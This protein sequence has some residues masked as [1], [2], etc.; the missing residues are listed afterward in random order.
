MTTMAVDT[1]RTGGMTKEE[2]LVVF[3]SSTGTVLEWY[4]FYIYGTLG[5][6]LAK[7]FFSNVPPN[8]GFIF[9]LLAFA[10]GFAVRPFGALIFGRVGDVIGRKN[11]FLMCMT[12]MGLS[13][14]CIGL[15][16]G[17]ATWGIFAPTVLVILRLAQG[18]ALGGE[19]GGAA[20]YVAEHAPQNKRGYYTSWIQ[21]T[22]TLGLFIALLLILTIRTWIGE[23]AFADW[24]WR[25]PFL[26]SALLLMVTLWIGF[27]LN[28][29]PL[30]QK[31]IAEGKQSK[32]PLSEAFGQWSNAKIA[33]AALFGA[34][35]GEAV[36][37]YGGQFYALFF[38]TQTLK[39]P[40]VTAWIL[41]MVA[42]AL[43][44]PGFILFGWLS[45]KIGRKPIML[46]G[47]ALAAVTYFYIFAGITHFVNPKLEQALAAAPV[48][49]TADPAKC[50]FQF[51]ATGTETFTTGCDIIKST[52]V[53]LSVNYENVAA[54]AGAAAS[55]K[56]GDQTIT[57]D[58]PNVAKVI[59]DAIKAHGY[60][61]GAD[62][63]DINYPM[64]ILLLWIL[65]IY[66]TMVYGPIAAWLVELF[67][68]RI[69]YSGFSLPYHIGNGWFGGF[70]PATVFA[71]VAATGNIY[72][73]L[74]YPIV[75]ACMSF[76][77]GLIFLP[78]TK[79]RD[80]SQG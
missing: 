74:W 46:A 69:R 33:L 68:T 72:S 9:A 31:M 50:S 10:A 15:M 49:V 76:V 44:T 41:I 77:V 30:F 70:L 7:F 18:L 16:P 59:T 66:V 42:L 20:I 78:E 57:S 27:K 3:A 28:E 54:P 1:P 73:G 47:F 67:P 40:Y 34:T 62:V 56:I 4:D 58:T 79:D 43:G 19:Y 24:G 64:A 8:V 5:A 45:D 75:V 32:R 60:P 26:V 36:V 35:A 61:P 51:K 38:L 17:Y 39:V 63:N 2:R 12:I 22:A 65:V 25:I 14:F 23:A 71:I 21:T 80:I 6:F 52:L 48:T 11:T 55:V 53:N 13:T 37:W 29:A